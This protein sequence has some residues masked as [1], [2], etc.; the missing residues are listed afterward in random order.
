MAVLANQAY[1]LADLATMFDKDGNLVDVVNMLSQDNEILL[2]IPWVEANSGMDHMTSVFTGLPSAFWR[3]YNAGIP[4]SKATRAPLK[5]TCAMLEAL[6]FVDRDLAKI[7]GNSAAWRLQEERGFLDGMNQQMAQTVFYGNQLVTPASF[8]GLSSRMSTV[9]VANANSAVNV[10]DAGGT[11]S[12]NTSMWFCGW[13]PN[14]GHGLYP[15]GSEAGLQV[16]DVTTNAPIDDGTGTGRKFFALQTHY[17]WDCGMTI[18]DWRYFVRIANIDTTLLTGSSAPNLIAMMIAAVNKLPAAARKASAVQMAGPD[19]AGMPIT[20]VQPAI[21]VNR[22]LRTAL[23]LQVL[24][25][26]NLLL[27]LEQWAGM[28]VLTFLGIPI[29]TCDALLNTEGRVI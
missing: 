24:N 21:Y 14:T 27:Q 10:I 9:N 22:T 20:A 23:H 28:P 7:N 12:T 15:K 4:S 26:S 13:G 29:R 5:D 3:Q 25:K 19:A 18:R 11:G 8:S 16:Q 17:K 1:T 2:D 6:S